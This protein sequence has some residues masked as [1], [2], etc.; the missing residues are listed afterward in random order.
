[1]AGHSKWANIKH[2]KAAQDS[3]RGKVFSHLIKKIGSAARRGGGDPESNTE[4]RLYLQKAKAANVPNDNVDRAILKA[5]GQLEGIS[6]TDFTYEGYGPG[7]IAILLEG[8]TDNKNRTVAEIRHA[9]SK[10]GGNLGENGC[11]AWMFQAKGILSVSEDE[12]DDVDAFMETALENGAEDFDHEDSVVTVTTDPAD[13]LTLREAV[14]AAGVKDFL[15][16]EITKVSE[17]DVEPDLKAVLRVMKL[18][19]TLEDSDDIE[20]VYHNMEISAEVAEAL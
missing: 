2:R 6:Y 1:M 11:V 16:D 4:L 12:L 19:E 17:T 3:K 8:S 7:G 18:I 14:I 15:T 20:N 9:F 5:T 10:A 13:F